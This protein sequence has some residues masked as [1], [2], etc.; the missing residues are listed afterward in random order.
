M[1]I[2][3]S[4]AVPHPPIILPEIGQGEEKKIQKTI[5]AYDTVMKAAAD[6][7]PDTLVITSPHAEL[8]LDYFH[9]APGSHARGSFAQFRA[10]QVEIAVDYD[11]TLASLI[12][13]DAREAGIPAGFEGERNPA[14]DHATMIPLYFF[15]KYKPLDQVRVVRIG[16]SGFPADVHY[17]LG[18]CIRRA[19]DQL[20]RRVVF[21]ASGDLSHKLLPEGPYGAVP[22]GPVFDR[23]CTECLEKGDFL[24]LLTLDGSLCTRAAECGLRSFWIMTGAWDGVALKSRLLSYEGPF[25]VG[26]GVASFYPEGPDPSRQFLLPLLQYQKKQ[27]EERIAHE[28]PY[29]KLARLSVET[30]VKTGEPARLPAQLPDEMRTTRAGAFV[31]LHLHGQLRGCIGTISPMHSCVAEEI[32]QNGISAATRDPRFPPVQPWELPDLEYNVD[33]LGKPEPVA[34]AGQLDPKKYGVIV[35]SSRDERKGLLLP[36]LDGVDTTAEQISIARQKGNIGAREPIEL[37]RFQVVRHK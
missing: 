10:P 27:K 32:L 31:S 5:D 4:F 34:D 11:T 20:G 12:A 14:L 15:R 21:I 2:L 37:Y 36:D 6:L 8:Y 3:A 29:V 30:F 22:E 7:N 13:D 19:V 28:D 33:V 24:R 26:Y 16:L 17:K 25:G 23:A 9:I 18:Q 1:T 35:K